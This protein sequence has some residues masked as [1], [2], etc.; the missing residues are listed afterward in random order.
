[1]FFV[2]ASVVKFS[3][4]CDNDAVPPQSGVKSTASLVS[5]F[6]GLASLSEGLSVV[7]VEV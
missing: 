6:Q 3:L 2:T 1:M 7:L 4:Y 5:A